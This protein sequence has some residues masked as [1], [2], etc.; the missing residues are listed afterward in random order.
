MD[1]FRRA[2]VN[3]V[4][5]VIATNDEADAGKGGRI[6]GTAR[7][8]QVQ[9]CLDKTAVVLET[10]IAGE[11]QTGAIINEALGDRGFGDSAHDFVADATPLRAQF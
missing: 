2:E 9:R 8:C 4:S 7:H 5:L 6:K 3:R 11:K 10:D 1:I